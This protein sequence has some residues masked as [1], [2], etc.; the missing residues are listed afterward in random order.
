[1]KM[2][3]ITVCINIIQQLGD[4]V[5]QAVLELGR[6]SESFKN[7]HATRTYLC[8]QVVS[9]FCVREYCEIHNIRIIAVL[10]AL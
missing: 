10:S 4:L 9:V 1:M 2:C 6:E 7:F 8:K 5:I 3:T